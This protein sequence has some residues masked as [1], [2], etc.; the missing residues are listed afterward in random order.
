MQWS[1]LRIR[2]F[3]ETRAHYKFRAARLV[4][5]DPCLLGV[6]VRQQPQDAEKDLAGQPD[7]QYNG[8]V[9]TVSTS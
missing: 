3:N 8:P 9:D 1:A 5:P 6:A 2:R 4:L 7:R